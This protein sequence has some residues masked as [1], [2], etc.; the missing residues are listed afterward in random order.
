MPLTIAIPV[1]QSGLQRLHH[2]IDAIEFLGGLQKHVVVFCCA[3]SVMQQVPA[4]AARLRPICPSVY[5][6]ALPREPEGPGRFSAFNMI[7]RE[8]VELLDKRG[9][10][11]PWFW[12]EEDMTP[13]RAGWADRLELEYHRNGQ[14]FMGVRRKAS[15]VVRGMNGE[16]LPDT[17]PQTQGDYMVAVGIYPAK[18]KDFSTMYKYPDPAGNMATDVMIRHEVAKYLH[19]TPLIGHHYR[20]GNYRRENGRLICDDFEHVEGHP[21]Y[22]GE[23]SEMAFVVHG[24]RDGSLS[25]LI[26]SETPGNVSPMSQAQAQTSSDNSELAAL[27]AQ[28]EEMR[29]DIANMQEQW[30]QRENSYAD[31]IERLK[32]LAQKGVNINVSGASSQAPSVSEAESE[33]ANAPTPKIEDV[34]KAVSTSQIK[35]MLGDWAADFKISKEEMRKLIESEGSGLLIAKPGPPFVKVAA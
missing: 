35:R 28:N 18:F 32:E 9:N 11:N 26:L 7:F 34:R 25:N 2:S 29:R 4:L 8:T 12:W 13:I 27:K 20:T 21:K 10:A 23:V 31:E 30:R 33:L 14:P 15:E 3:P 17:H 1:S 16:K 5:I 6:E 24:C 19:H 22:G